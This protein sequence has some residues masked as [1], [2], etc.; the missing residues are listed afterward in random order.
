[1]ASTPSEGPWFEHRLRVRYGETDQMGRAH[2]ASYVLYLEEARTRMMDHL[3]CSY[4]ALEADGIGLPVRRLE[5]RYREGAG[6]DE[7]LIVRTRLEAM[8]AA[9]LR[10]AYELLRAADGALVATGQT[11]LACVDLGRTP[12]APV[13]LPALVRTLFEASSRAEER[14]EGVTES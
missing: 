1:M 7:E 8:G 4:S 9:S 6:Y 13:G 12:P 5:L 11:E 3:G 14:S 10:F 2:H